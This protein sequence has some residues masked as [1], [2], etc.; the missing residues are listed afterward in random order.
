[1]QNLGILVSSMEGN[2]LS[3]IGIPTLKLK[4]VY[5]DF[6]MQIYFKISKEK[7]SLLCFT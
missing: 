3:A 4:N 2:S 6:Q 1:M 5:L 7:P